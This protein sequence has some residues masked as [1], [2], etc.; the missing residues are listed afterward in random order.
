MLLHEQYLCKVKSIIEEKKFQEKYTFSSLTDFRRHRRFSF[1]DTMQYVIGNTREPSYSEA[2]RYGKITHRKQV[3]DTAIRKA[4]SKIN[5]EAFHEVFLRA[6]EVIPKEKKFYGYQ[7]IAVDGMKG[8]LPKTPDFTRK[9]GHSK[10]SYPLFHAVSGYDMLNEVFVDGLFHFGGVSEYKFAITL[11]D[12]YIQKALKTPRIWIFDR[13]FPNLLL[14]QYL[15]SHNENFVMRVSRS[16]LREVN[17]FRNGTAMDE[18][19]KICYDNRRRQTSRVKSNGPTEFML[20]CVRIKLKRGSDEILITNLSREEFP[21][22][23]IG[24]IYRLRWG[25]ETA[26]NYLK[27]AVFIE[28]FTSREKNRITQ[29]FYATL[30]VNNFVTCVDESAW[31]N[32]PAKKNGNCSGESTNIALTAEIPH[33]RRIQKLGDY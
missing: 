11:I 14:I 6:A 29:D 22:E 18:D 23:D 26:H 10:Q 7:L 19:V 20:R 9:Y 32:M 15:I 1:E 21:T 4:R 3:S 5:A 12:E 16:F 2:E 33:E 13:G 24:E 25:I 27:N 31:A 30:I 8:E 17:E 28:E